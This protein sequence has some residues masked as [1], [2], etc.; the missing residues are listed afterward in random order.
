M[1]LEPLHPERIIPLIRGAVDFQRS[2]SGVVPLRLPS[3]TLAF[4]PDPSLTMMARMGSGV[5]VSA[6]TDSRVI[7]LEVEETGLRMLPGARLPATFDLYVDGEFTARQ[8][9]R[10]G[11]TVVVEPANPGVAPVIEPGKS[12]ILRFD[13]L[14]SGRK[15]IELWL[16]QSAVTRIRAL[17]VDAQSRIAPFDDQRPHWIHHGSSISHA[18]EAESGAMTW[19][20]VAAR[21]AGYQ[22]TNLGFGGQCMLD[23]FTARTIAAQ[24]AHLISLKL[25]INVVNGDTM[26]ERTFRAAVLNFLDLVRDKRPHTPLLV[27]SP[28]LC[29]VAENHPGPTLR[30]GS[31]FSVP[32]RPAALR[33]GAL[34]LT[35]IR[36]ILESTVQK[37]RDAGDPNLHYL[38]GRTLFGEPDVHLLPDGLHPDARGQVLMGERFVAACNDLLKTAR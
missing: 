13:G 35:I 6:V 34:T 22:L 4:S 36:D 10:R 38:D 18:M 37:R 14:S 23:G 16:P 5:R 1:P 28:I 32:E 31:G 2:G 12:S 17:R 25:G 24:P 9:A 15:R 3:R 29:P 11:P 8:E 27:I 21:H 7:E 30:S 33:A 20:A 26:R 19:P